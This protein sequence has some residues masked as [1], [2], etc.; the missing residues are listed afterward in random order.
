[1]IID[2]ITV[3]E[4]GAT[5]GILKRELNRL[6]KASWFD[7][8]KRHHVE[9]TADRFTPEHAR[10]AGY[11]KRKG[12]NLAPGSKGFKRSYYGRKLRS[13]TKGGGPGRA[14]PLVYS[15]K[16]QQQS[17]FPSIGSTASGA[18]IRF[19]T[20]VFNFRHPKSRIRMSDEFRKVLPE[21]KTQIVDHYDSGLDRRLDAVTTTKKQTIG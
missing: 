5:P 3:R 12:E 2:K 21:E 20:P 17:K 14:D 15:G 10:K 6:S 8:A 16:S 19:R 9:N 4:R 1:M 13:D 18:K 11:H 7:A